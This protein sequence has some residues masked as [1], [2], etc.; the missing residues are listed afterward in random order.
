MSRIAARRSGQTFPSAAAVTVLFVAAAAPTLAAPQPASSEVAVRT[1]DHPGYGRLV[2]DMPVGASVEIASEG[3]RLLLVF[4]GVDRL[5][6]PSLTPRNVTS[7]K[8]DGATATLALQQGA[9]VRTVRLGNR[10]IVDVMDAAA[11]PTDT[12]NIASVPTFETGVVTG[13]REAQG[14]PGK[15]GRGVSTHPPAAPAI[16]EP[17][18][19]QPGPATL[20][21]PSPPIARPGEG[22]D[23]AAVE[24]NVASATPAPGPD[25]PEGRPS[26]AE[27]SGVPTLAAAKPPSVLPGIAVQTE[28]TAVERNGPVSAPPEPK[29]E[30]TVVTLPAD[31]TVGAAAFRRDNTAVIVLDRRLPLPPPELPGAVVVPGA[32]TTM[33][34][35]P[36]AQDRQV[37]LTRS[38]AG[39]S[40][41][42]AT[43]GGGTGQMPLE[44]TPDGVSFSL[45]RQGRSVT[46]VDPVSGG[47]LLV[48]TSLADGSISGV[49]AE[50]RGPEY[51]ILPTWLGVVVEPLSDREELRQGKGG[52]LL[53]GAK[54]SAQVA[55]I[56]ADHRFDLPNEPVPALLNRMNLQL[57]SAAAAQ[58]RARTASRLAA[59]Q[60]MLA[61]GMGVE[62][63]ALLTQ[64]ASDDPQAA[65]DVQLPALAAVAAVL[66]GRCDEASALDDPRLQDVA[67]AQM[68]RGLRDRG[69]GRD[70]AAAR[71]LATYRATAHDYPEPLRREVWPEVAEAAVEAGITL[72]PEDMTPY[73]AALLLERQGKV[74]DALTAWHAVAN[75]S[76]RLASVRASRRA[77]ELE[78][79]SGRISAG[80]A[81]DRFD[82]LLTGWRGDTREFG[83]RLRAAELR[84]AAGQWRT[85]LDL[86]RATDELF[87]AQH[88]EIRRKKTAVFEAM[89]TADGAGLSPVDVIVLASDFA[90]CVPDDASG[91]KLAALLAD[92]L[93]TLDLSARAIPVLQG[94]MK[95]TA[96]GPARAEFG[97]RLSQLLLEAGDDKGALAALQASASSDLSPDRSEARTL[98]AAKALAAGGNM[99]DA[100]SLLQK[101]PS[102]EADDLRATLFAKAGDWHGSLSAL[103]D[104][105]A[106]VVPADG[107][108]DAAAQA[109]VVRQATA[110]AQASDLSELHS[111]QRQLPRMAGAQADLVRV[112]TQ[113]PVTSTRE[114]PRAATELALA[115]NIPQQIQA[116]GRR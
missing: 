7:L 31:A 92:K 62:A 18:A 114:L 57:A 115:R 47:T 41:A 17:A 104:L 111:L 20:N 13:V 8:M 86:L 50:R 38:P 12:A 73:A 2:F 80:Q 5:G 36:L 44:A 116:I 27:A 72:P 1:G 68:W 109:I 25:R 112:L 70:T 45:P 15:L 22:R 85:A 46:V 105:A 102:P 83:L 58:P 35:L 3:S 9:K 97:T 88:D 63:Q 6:L 34:Q 61:L 76:D 99:Q 74:E 90:D 10:L 29:P 75:S 49:G 94:L 64:A 95:A 43:T 30:R 101:S 98:I 89:L 26:S 60:A 19:A 96:A 77:I 11:P 21:P 16:T 51:T 84:S 78:L 108:L 54:P 113:A 56:P 93:M 55:D 23:P 71:D 81:S 42:L 66:A 53:H 79:A 110:A 14:R 37:Q 65:A 67:E 24:P 69:L 32:V 103:S 33:V 59:A 87:P 91:A 52:F 48:G 100:V 107:P 106:K 82:S 40:V 39:W 28:P 4:S